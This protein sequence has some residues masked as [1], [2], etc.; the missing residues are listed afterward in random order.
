MS[1]VN[2]LESFLRPPGLGLYTV[3]T[4][5]G[6]AESL[7]KK[8]YGG[9]P[10]FRGDDKSFRGDDFVQQKWKLAFRKIKQA[11]VILLGFP[12]DNGA[13]IK[14]GSNFAPLEIRH[15]LYQNKKFKTWIQK[16][17]VVDL[18][19]I[20]VIPQLLEDEMLSSAQKK[21]SQIALYGKK[22]NLP[23]SPLSLL[24]KTANL[25]FKLNP[26]AKLMTLGGD[27]SMSWPLICAYHAH[28]SPFS[29]LHF[30]AH[31]DLLESR[32]GV[33]H[34]YGTW[35]YH[36]NEKIGKKQRLV[37]VGIR[38]SQKPK[39]HWEST[40]DVKQ[41]WAKEI[42][43]DPISSMQKILDHLKSL[44]LKKVYI[45]NDIDG[46]DPA[47]AACTGT[48]EPKG[49]TP[50]FVKILI[51]Q[52]GKNFDVIGADLNEV[53]PILAAKDPKEPEKTLRLAAQYTQFMIEAMFKG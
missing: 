29:I 45:S 14:R 44:K 2:E 51:D 9:D 31:T 39:K 26:K 7:L 53:A 49:L 27:H 15:H 8:I 40:L 3:S 32:L 47:S 30:D 4:G 52:V 41:F 5:A 42:L 18:G 34:C 20:L 37:Q 11:K 22:T 23:V 35:A 6:M 25:I 48:P 19:D 46:T 50:H 43:K 12:S 38:A 10:R 28:H 33:D 16:N 24:E 13:G 17:T 36:A 1:A 21:K